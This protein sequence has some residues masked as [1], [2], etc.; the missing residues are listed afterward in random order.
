MPSPVDLR[1]C[2][3]AHYKYGIVVCYNGSIYQYGDLG[4]YNKVNAEIALNMRE[5]KEQG[6]QRW[7]GNT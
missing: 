5:R 1:T 2:H 7:M 4:K 3:N 6:Q